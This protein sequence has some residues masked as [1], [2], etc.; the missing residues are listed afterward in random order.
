M[1]TVSVDILNEFKRNI[2]NFIDELIDQFPSEG[3][4]VIVR[5]IL[6]DMAKPLDI[7]TNFISKILPFKDM[8]KARN[9]SFFLSSGNAAC[10]FSQLDKTKVNHFKR[11]W[12]S[13]NLDKE[14]R[15][16][17]W[18]WFDTFIVLAERFQASQTQQTSQS[19]E[20]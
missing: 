19:S 20:H 7:M 5:I 18:T 10:L 11:I 17:I 3:D 1:S 12:K 13:S 9:D 15:D 16:I 14:D 8:I 6:K 4:L 2:I